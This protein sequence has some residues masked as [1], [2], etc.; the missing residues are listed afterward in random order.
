MTSKNLHKRHFFSLKNT[1]PRTYEKSI[2]NEIPK[3]GYFIPSF[4]IAFK[5]S[6]GFDIAHQVLIVLNKASGKNRRN[7]N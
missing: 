6:L 4:N 2:I 1:L 5:L 3:Y 7:Y